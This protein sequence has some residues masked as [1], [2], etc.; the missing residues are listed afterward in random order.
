MEILSKKRNVPVGQKRSAASASSSS[1][2]KPSPSKK[3]K[4]VKGKKSSFIDDR[5]AV[6]KDPEYETDPENS[7]DEDDDDDSGREYSDDDEVETFEDGGVTQDLAAA[8]DDR[9]SGDEDVVE[10]EVSED[11][12]GGEG[13]EDASGDEEEE[14]METGGLELSDAEKMKQA[15]T[16]VSKYD[17][18]SKITAS[19]TPNERLFSK[20]C[21]GP[22]HAVG[23]DKFV[24]GEHSFW[25]PY[26]RDPHMKLSKKHCNQKNTINVAQEYWIDSIGQY[27]GKQLPMTKDEWKVAI[28]MIQFYIR[29]QEK[30]EH[31]RTAHNKLAAK[32]R[33]Q[34]YKTKRQTRSSTG[35]KTRGG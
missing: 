19:P 2:G 11:E 7:Q 25:K 14:P 10:E 23:R 27:K 35:A 12:E 13:E 4:L 30:E 6:D 16:H 34:R 22:P 33:Q 24:F 9:E 29:E 17:F 5:E 26:D 15:E 18:I 21:M 28:P 31:L 32:L 8:D 3:T 1:K 20:E